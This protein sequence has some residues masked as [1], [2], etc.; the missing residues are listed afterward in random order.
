MN[1]ICYGCG[2]EIENARWNAVYCVPC[3]KKFYCK[4]I[5]SPRKASH[6]IVTIAIRGGILPK[7]NGSVK[8]VD[9]GKPADHYDHRDYMKPLDV[10]PVCRSCNSRRGP[11]INHSKPI[12]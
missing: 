6:Q 8:C 1:K 12:S 7:L 2:C 4:G 9:C 11:A 3:R 10:S 5:D